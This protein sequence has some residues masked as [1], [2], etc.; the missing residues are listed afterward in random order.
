[1]SLLTQEATLN[2]AFIINC[3]SNLA[4]V[5]TSPVAFIIIIIISLA[6]FIGLITAG[7]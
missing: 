4:S 2:R 1:M 3:S 6:Y 5:I 7:A